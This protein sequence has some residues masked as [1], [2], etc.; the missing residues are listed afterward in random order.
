MFTYS[1]LNNS[2][3][4]ISIKGK[5]SVGIVIPAGALYVI[6]V[7]DSC[8]IQYKVELHRAKKVYTSGK[9]F[10]LA[11]RKIH[12]MLKT[13]LYEYE[14]RVPNEEK[15]EVA[16]P[17]KS[18]EVPEEVHEVAEEVSV[19]ETP[20]EEPKKAKVKEPE[21]E[22][23]EELAT[24]KV[25]EFNPVMY[26]G[27]PEKIMVKADGDGRSISFKSSNKEIATVTRY[28]NVYPQAP[29]FTDITI[30]FNGATKVLKL[31]VLPAEPENPEEE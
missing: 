15:V 4:P 8:P 14:V 13:V 31:E 16:E 2:G 20:V 12:A 30:T 6:K 28:G 21:P 10:I 5:D 1:F 18:E 25:M 27:K 7:G 19:V 24:F 3:A 22:V 26:V 11:L 17:S 23:P 29:G 9:D